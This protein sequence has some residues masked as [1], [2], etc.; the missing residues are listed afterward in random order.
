[1]SGITG[2]NTSTAFKKKDVAESRLPAVGFKK[3]RFMHQATEGQ[4]L[5]QLTALTAPSVATANGF[6]Q[7]NVSDLVKTDLYL[8]KENVELESSIRGKLTQFLAYVINGPSTIK[9]L[10]DAEENEIITGVIDLSARTGSTLVDAEPL[11]ST[12]SLLAGETDFNVGIPFRIG[13]F[14][15]AQHG[16]VMVFLDNQLVYRNSGN[17]PP[18]PGV[19][20]EYQEIHA[21]GGLGVLIRFNSPDLVN[22]RNVTVIS[23]G[24]LVERPNGSLVA[25]VEALQGQIDSIVPTVAELAGVDETDF[26][27]TPNQVD[28]KAFGDLVLSL[29]QRLDNVTFDNYDY[30]EFSGGTKSGN[31][32]LP[33]TQLANKSAGAFDVTAFISSGEIRTLKDGWYSFHG[34]FQY[35]AGAFT[36]SIT[37]NNST[38]TG[39]NNTDVLSSLVPQSAQEHEITWEGFLPA[40]SV[41]SF[42]TN[43]TFSA[44]TAV[45]MYFASYLGTRNLGSI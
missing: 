7:P 42:N 32:S 22:D 23:I 1:M 45:Q 33:S 20:G 37:R 6:V 43:G 4:N 10:F 8:F 35:S 28:L 11:V 40:G 25:L 26:Q 17:N 36:T 41:I 21:G 2:K 27:A 18:G 15:S 24:S 3:I 14:P 31:R 13:M 5:I 39:G 44:N 38:A 16:A 12:G 9:L 34:K 19:D 29:K 30:I